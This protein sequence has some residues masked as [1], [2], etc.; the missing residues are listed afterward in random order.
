MTKK[1][2]TFAK[3]KSSRGTIAK[4][5][6]DNSNGKI[7]NDTKKKADALKV[8]VVKTRSGRVSKVKRNPNDIYWLS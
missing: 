5:K 7:V 2:V 6:V 1:R 4:S 3:G 8:K